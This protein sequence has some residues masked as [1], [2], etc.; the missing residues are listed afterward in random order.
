[1]EQK[2][3]IQT[4]GRK[5]AYYRLGEGKPRKLILVHGNAS[6]A[7]F[8]FP[9]IYQLA[10]H[11]DVVAPDLNGFGDTEATPVKA[12]TALRDWAEDVNALAEALGFSRFALLGWSLGGGVAMRYVQ[13][14][15][16][17]TTY[18]ILLSPMPPY[19]FGGTKGEDGQMYDRNGWGAPGGFAN[20]AF[21]AKLAEKDEGDDQFAA[22]SVLEKSLFA[23]GW[24]MEKQ[25]QDLF[26]KELL[27][28]QLGEDYYPGNYIPQAEFPY[29]LPG[30]KGISNA[31]APQYANVSG[32]RDINPKPPILWIRGDA[33]SL[34]SDNSFSD[35]AVL[36]QMGIV[37]GYPGAEVFPPQPMVAQ[38]RKVLEQ[39]K[40]NGG[41]YTETVFPGC[42]H[43]S[44]LEEP[45][46]FVAALTEFI[47]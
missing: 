29:V 26:V 2:Q 38:T 1:M 10:E 31:L 42:S 14:H 17:K 18:L 34:V 19:G 4:R 43:A 9:T 32:I 13:L 33:D 30:E 45:D 47:A 39:Y 11:Y 25:W 41:A 22:R 8:F 36:G 40:E 5:T 20:P 35:L 28:M 24:P 3:F 27:K 21:L 23:K 16:E 12:P 46:K 37:P 6:S 44:H 15:P 7:A